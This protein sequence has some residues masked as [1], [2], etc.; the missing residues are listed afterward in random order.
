MALIALPRIALG[1]N[2][3]GHFCDA[4]DTREILSVAL[5]KGLNFVDTSDSYSNGASET[6][7]G[8]ATRAHRSRWIIATKAGIGSDESSS[9]LGRRTRIREKVEGSLRRLGTDWIDIYQMHHFDPDT[10]LEE[11]LGTLA[12]LKSEGKI[13]HAGVSN[14]S[15]AQIRMALDAAKELAV[16]RI[17]AVQNH[18]NVLKRSGALDWLPICARA[19]VN[20]LAYGVLARGLLSGKYRRDGPLPPES[21]ASTSESVREDLDA[22]VLEVV[23]S[24]SDLARSEGMNVGELAIA[25]ALNQPGVSAVIVGVRSVGQLLGHLRVVEAGFQA[26]ELSQIEAIVGAPDRFAGFNLGGG[27][28]TR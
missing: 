23:R 18:L 6:Y 22:E 15:G 3:F 9:G 11:T 21:R 10:P 17:D 16:D 20:V 25:W 8:A 14:Y 5:D 28:S 2:V 24:L 27:R 7:I 1:G 19:N 4:R 12:D 13:R 26:P